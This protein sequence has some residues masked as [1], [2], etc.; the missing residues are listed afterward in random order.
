MYTYGWTR[1][2]QQ[3]EG[4]DKKLKNTKINK[5]SDMAAGSSPGAG[6]MNGGKSTPISI[7]LETVYRTTTNNARQHKTCGLTGTR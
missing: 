6:S 4:P 5:I 1:N 2:L 3:A 7:L